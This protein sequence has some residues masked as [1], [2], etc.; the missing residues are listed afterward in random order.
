VSLPFSPTRSGGN[1]NGK[2]MTVE[3]SAVHRGKPAPAGKRLGFLV[4]TTVDAD[5]VAGVNARSR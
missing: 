3:L 2:K 1:E 4:D 5:V